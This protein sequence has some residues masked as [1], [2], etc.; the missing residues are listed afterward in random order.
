MTVTI[1]KTVLERALMFGSLYGP[2]TDDRTAHALIS[3]IN[4]HIFDG[5]LM[6]AVHEPGKTCVAVIM[7]EDDD[8]EGEAVIPITDI[9][10]IVGGRDET[11]SVSWRGIIKRL[12][13]P[14]K[15]DIVRNRIFLNKGRDYFA[16]IPVSDDELSKKTNIPIDEILKEMKPNLKKK[17]V[18]YKGDIFENPIVLK[19]I[20]LKELVED[21]KTNKSDAFLFDIKGKS[22]ETVMSLGNRSRFTYRKIFFEEKYTGPDFKAKVFNGV[23]AFANALNDDDMVYI[24]YNNQRFIFSSFRSTSDGVLLVVSEKIA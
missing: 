13:D 10:T 11:G 9:S 4:L 20:V 12:K 8:I 3:C 24:F 19:S 15:V 7:I 22:D 16:D 23:E 21:E 6:I 17:I 2:S 1:P 5:L 18:E 14:I